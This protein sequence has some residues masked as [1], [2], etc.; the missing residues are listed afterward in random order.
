VRPGS[1]FWSGRVRYVHARGELGPAAVLARPDG[2]VAWADDRVDA[3]P[4]DPAL[5]SALVEWCGLAADGERPDDKDR[6]HG[7]ATQ[8]RTS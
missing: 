4:D 2:Y 7:A 3:S 6:P 8:P 5:R 1:V